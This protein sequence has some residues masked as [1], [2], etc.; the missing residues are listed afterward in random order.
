M[1]VHSGRGYF[2][3][4]DCKDRGRERANRRT[5]VDSGLPP[6]C[7]VTFNGIQHKGSRGHEEMREVH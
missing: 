1:I 7:V 6:F 5:T 3:S 2:E 4:V